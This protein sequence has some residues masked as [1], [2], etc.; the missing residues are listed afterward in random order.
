MRKYTIIVG[1]DP[2]VEKSGLA[3][4]EKDEEMLYLHSMTFPVLLD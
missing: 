1:I 2:D 4:Y 3:L